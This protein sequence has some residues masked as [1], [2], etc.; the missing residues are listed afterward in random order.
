MVEDQPQREGLQKQNMHRKRLIILSL[1]IGIFTWSSVSLGAPATDLRTLLSSQDLPAGWAPVE[2]PRVYSK[3]TLFEHVDGQA[4]LYLTYGF[5]RS[6][7]AIFQ[8]VKDPENQIEVDIYDMGNVLHAF[9]VFSRFRN[10]DRPGGIGLDSYLDD[11]S[12]FFYKGKCFVMLYATETNASNL[13]QLAMTISEK[14]VDSSPPPKEIHLFPKDGL[15]TGS[16]Q[17]FPEGLLGHDFLGRGFQASYVDKVETGDKN[18]V[19]G[20]V[21]VE[22]NIKS[23]AEGKNKVEDNPQAQTQESHLFLAIFKSPNAAK[24]ALTTYKNY[25]SKK[26]KILPGTPA[27]F[28]PDAWKGEDPYQGQLIVLQRGLHLMGAA[29]FP[30]KRGELYLDTFMKNIR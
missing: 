11:R 13:K 21:K 16:I 17:Y 22:E 23:K 1:W 7:F 26:G 9:G 27:T 29:G 24:E 19:E 18:K 4:I 25:I 20:K 8:N 5:Q 28:G 6:V 3:K 15:K 30:D 10:D 12:I 2:G 14:I